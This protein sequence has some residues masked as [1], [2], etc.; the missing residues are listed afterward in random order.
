MIPDCATYLPETIDLHGVSVDRFTIEKSDAFSLFRQR[1]LRPGTYTRLRVDGRLWM[2]DT[3]AEKSDHYEAVRSA[4]G[5]CLVTG[6]GLGM[7]ANAMAQ[8]NEVSE[9]TVIEIC[10]RVIAAI[11]PHLHEKI[12]VIE[13]NALDWRPPAGELYG[14]VWHD[15]WPNICADNLPEMTRLK[16]RF[17]RRATWQ[18][19]WAQNLC[20]RAA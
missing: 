15:I 19:C 9:I 10:Q 3:P 13:A 2:S 16:R 8:K 7:V 5:H 12:S 4:Q 20:R 11:T 1:G 14:A 18:G 17:S 6:L